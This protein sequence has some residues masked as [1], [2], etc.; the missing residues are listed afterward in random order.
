MKEKIETLKF[1]SECIRKTTLEKFISNSKFHFEFEVDLEEEII[2]SFLLLNL[3]YDRIK[4]GCLEIDFRN[5]HFYFDTSDFFS[6]YNSLSQSDDEFYEVDIV[7]FDCNNELVCKFKNDLFSEFNALIYNF[8]SYR[9]FISYITEKHEFIDYHN[10]TIKEFIIVSQHDKKGVIKIGYNLN[11]HRLSTLPDISTS[12]LQLTK[13]FNQKE[14]V[15]FFRD[16]V[17][18]LFDIKYDIKDRFFEMTKALPMLLNNSEKDYQIFLKNFNLESIK[19]RFKEQ[20]IKY[21]ENLD[22]NLDSINKQ[23]ASIPLTFSATAFAGYQVK[24]KSFILILIVLGYITYTVLSIKSLQIAIFNINS[25]KEDIDNESKNIKE[26]SEEVFKEFKDDF[27]KINKK[28]EKLDGIIRL[29]KWSLMI[30]L[31]LFACFVIYQLFITTKSKESG[32]FDLA[33]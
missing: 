4:G 11:E 3:S 20:R 33:L 22:K 24:D 5:T 27:E 26:K 21:F 9:Y 23:I 14:F 16:R 7:I 8:R 6:R 13:N 10:A 31:I 17:F 12:I 1:I 32:H 30:L 25:V 19:S 28:V 18:D 2:E 15:I 29:I